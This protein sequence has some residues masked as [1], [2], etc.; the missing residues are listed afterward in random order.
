[1][2]AGWQ[3]HWISLHFHGSKK[4]RLALLYEQNNNNFRHVY[5]GVSLRTTVALR[6]ERGNPIILIDLAAEV[7]T[8]RPLLLLDDGYSS[9]NAIDELSTLS[10]N[11]YVRVQVRFWFGPVHYYYLHESIGWLTKTRTNV[12]TYVCQRVTL[13]LTRFLDAESSSAQMDMK[14]NAIPLTWQIKSIVAQENIN[15]VVGW[16]FRT[17]IKIRLRSS[18]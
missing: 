11:P 6:G 2:L 5:A 14:N 17:I 1:M 15:V 12:S 7:F 13:K 18:F 8:S 10:E 16:G 9:F 4:L 3:L